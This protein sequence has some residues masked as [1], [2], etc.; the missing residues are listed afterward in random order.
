MTK[1]NNTGSP[2]NL[3]PPLPTVDLL[4]IHTHPSFL[5]THFLPCHYRAPVRGPLRASRPMK[6]RLCRLDR[7]WPPP[8]LR[9]P[10]PDCQLPSAP[11]CR[12]HTSRSRP[13]LRPS[14]QQR[15]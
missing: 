13:Y 5:I 6:S 2:T 3:S 7:R 9:L 12:R 1:N 8:R 4:I 11:L 15:R 14:D 10:C